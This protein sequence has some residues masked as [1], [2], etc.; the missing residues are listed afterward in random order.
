[1]QH[2]DST[3][4][5][6]VHDEPNQEKLENLRTFVKTFGYK[7]APDLGGMKVAEE[8]NRLFDKAK[9]TPELSAIELMSLRCMAK[10]KYDVENIGHFGLAFK[11]YTH[12][13]SPIRRYP[14]MMVHRLL[15]NYLQGGKSADKAYYE[16]QCKHAS[17]REQVAA[18]AERASVKYKLVEFMQDKVGYTYDGTVSGLTDW[19]MYVEVLPTH[20]EG[21]VPLRDIRSDFFEFDEARYQIKGRHTKKIYTMGSPV[22][23]RVTRADL[24]QKQI[25]YELIE[26]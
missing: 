1:T 3:F 14:D 11:Y 23:I 20:I 19:G 18:D 9:D 25:D 10:A 16:G 21:M 8:L 6:R 17:E 15:A 4:V 26:D 2:R 13:T 22:K 7:L 12:F 24:D 5:Y